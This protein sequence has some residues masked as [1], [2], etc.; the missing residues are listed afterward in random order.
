MFEKIKAFLMR[1]TRA[2]EI[3]RFLIVGGIATAV[4]YFAMGVTIYLLSPSLYPDFFSVFFRADIDPSLPAKLLGTGIGFIFG[5]VAN[6][7]LS[8][9]FVFNEKGMSKTAKGFLAFALFSAV[10]FI[11]H[12]VGMYI[13]SDL[14]SI[15]QWAVKTIL[16]LVVLSYNYLSRRAFIFK[17]AEKETTYED[18]PDNPLL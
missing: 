4:D 13:M 14:L 15:N 11:L 7:L 8:V 1:P 16:T 10:G 17:K 6:Y 18:K 2:C 12:E 3:L 9:F 5:L